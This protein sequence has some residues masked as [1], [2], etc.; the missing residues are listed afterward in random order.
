MGDLSNTVLCLIMSHANGFRIVVR[1]GEKSRIVCFFPLFLLQS[2]L[3][4]QPHY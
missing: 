2:A 3:R 1:G 4:S